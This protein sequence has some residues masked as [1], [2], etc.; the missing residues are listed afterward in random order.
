MSLSR[1]K[2]PTSFRWF[3]T[4]NAFVGFSKP[5]TTK[6]TIVQSCAELML[7][8]SPHVVYSALAHPSTTNYLVELEIY[9]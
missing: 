7:T 8:L 6:G 1:L 4:M 5:N 9:G 3:E 2:R